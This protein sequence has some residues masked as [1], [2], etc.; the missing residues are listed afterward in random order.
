MHNKFRSFILNEQ[1]R[2]EHAERFL[3]YL[4]KY[5]A[6]V[7]LDLQQQLLKDWQAEIKQLLKRFP[8]KKPEDLLYATPALH[9]EQAQERI[10]SSRHPK[11]I[12]VSPSV[13]IPLTYSLH[14]RSLILRS[15]F[16]IAHD[17]L[18]QVADRWKEIF[19]YEKQ[20]RSISGFKIDGDDTELRFQ[21]IVSNHEHVGYK[22]LYVIQVDFGKLN[23]KTKNF[24]RVYLHTLY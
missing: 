10:T 12:E 15:L 6:E 17:T 3:T 19:T 9:V 18:T 14:E 16:K 20:G 13:K 2:V 5:H 7:V 11:L 8:E 21:M 4:D 23:S 22:T 24:D 1:V